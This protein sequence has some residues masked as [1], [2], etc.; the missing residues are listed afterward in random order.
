MQRKLICFPGGGGGTL[1]MYELRFHFITVNA[2][3]PTHIGFQNKRRKNL[4]MSR[5]QWLKIKEVTYPVAVAV[6]DAEGFM[7]SFQERLTLLSPI[8]AGVFEC[9]G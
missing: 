7:A 5:N 4:R 9:K 3:H 8:N 6:D 1:D 2:A